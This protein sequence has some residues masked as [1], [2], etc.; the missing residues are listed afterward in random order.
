MTRVKNA[1]SS[2][3]LTCAD[4]RHTPFSVFAAVPLILPF[5][6][7]F[8]SPLACAV[9]FATGT[10]SHD[11]TAASFPVPEG[12]FDATATYRT[13]AGTGRQYTLRTQAVFSDSTGRPRRAGP[14]H[15]NVMMVCFTGK[16]APDCRTKKSHRRAENVDIYQHAYFTAVCGL[17][18]HIHRQHFAL[19]RPQ[20]QTPC[21]YILL[22]LRVISFVFSRTALN[23]QV[24]TMLKPD[25][26]TTEN[27]IS[28]NWASPQ[29]SLIPSPELP[30]L[31]FVM[32]NTEK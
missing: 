8:L 23:I 6:A 2:S 3:R 25:R 28:V 16:V 1:S 11:G 5:P 20:K 32:K 18:F 9:F 14:R 31:H 4:S 21:N 17:K 27:T 15:G 22:L 29:G 30:Q 13:T 19:H 26:K 12:V 24:T 10:C 7:F